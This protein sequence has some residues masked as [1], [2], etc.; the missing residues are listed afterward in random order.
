MKNLYNSTENMKTIHVALFF[1]ICLWKYTK[2]C[3]ITVE[4]FNYLINYLIGNDMYISESD[5]EIA[6]QL[7]QTNHGNAF[8]FAIFSQLHVLKFMFLHLY[9]YDNIMKICSHDISPV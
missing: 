6:E 2:Y 3:C 9:N 4:Y 5:K 8:S 1:I 7:Q